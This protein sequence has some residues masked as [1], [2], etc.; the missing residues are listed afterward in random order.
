M[1]GGD[2]LRAWKASALGQ[3]LEVERDQAWDEQ[4]QPATDRLEAA[5]RERQPANIGDVLDGRPSA[6]GPLVVQAPRQRS[7]PLGREYLADGGGAQADVTGLERLTDLVDRVVALAQL[8]DRVAR[9]RL[10]RLHAGPGLG[11]HEE[12]RLGLAAKVVAHDLERGRCVA[13]RP[14]Y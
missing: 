7:E 5:R 4:E 8:D 10:L 3:R 12:L 2:H 14:S 6:V 13:E 11:R 9:G 1:L